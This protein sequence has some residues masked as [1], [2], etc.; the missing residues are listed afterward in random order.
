MYMILIILYIT[1]TCYFPDIVR[2]VPKLKCRVL[3]TIYQII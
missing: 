3:R 1:L 2:F